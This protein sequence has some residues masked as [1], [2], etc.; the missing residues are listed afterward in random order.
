MPVDE[1]KR[2]LNASLLAAG[3]VGVGC[4]LSSSSSPAGSSS[5]PSP[6]GIP[7]LVLG[8]WLLRRALYAARS[9]G[10]LQHRVVIAGDGAH[11]D[12]IA[13]RA[14]P[15]DVA[16]LQR[17]RRAHPAT[18]RRRRDATPASRVLGHDPRRSP[19][20]VRRRGRRDLLRRRRGRLGH[21][22]RRRSPGTSSSEDVQ[23]VVA[24]SVTD[25]SERAGQGP[26]GRR[27]AAD[28]HR[29]AA[30]AEHAS[31]AAS[32]P[33]TSSARSSLLLLFAPLFVVVRRS[34]SSRTT[35]A[36]CCSARP[37]SAATAR[38]SAA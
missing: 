38:R 36:R 37:A 32:G 8:R 5:S 4:Y 17:R 35:A 9:H 21:D 22:M 19:Q 24:P 11:V 33:S 34:G 18:G 28:P 31:R 2:M 13:E 6:I 12:E 16:R 3:F 29:E 23:V 26:P 1:Y 10:A 25:I 15:R 20:A 30:L 27:A 14:A 7:V